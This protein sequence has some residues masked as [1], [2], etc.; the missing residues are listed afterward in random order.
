MTEFDVNVRTGTLR[1]RRFGTAEG[2]PML[3]VPGLTGNSRIF[4]FVGEQIGTGGR[5]LLA[6]DLPGRGFSPPTEPGAYGWRNEAR[7]V[8]DLA[9]ALK[10]DRFDLVGYSAGA[11]VAMQAAVLVPSRIRRLILIDGLGRP[12]PAAFWAVMRTMQ[13]LGHVYPS[14][15]AYLAEVR[16]LGTVDPWS[17]YWDR[18]FR[19]ELRPALG[20]VRSRASL[21]A[22]W[23]DTLYG[24]SHD[25]RRFWS[26]IST[27]TLVLEATRPLARPD[28]LFVTRRDIDRA[29]QTLP[30]FK[31]AAVDAN[32]YGVVTH[33]ETV[34][35]ICEFIA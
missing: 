30:H 7:D 34:D 6:F 25:P 1:T 2:E 23:E 21:L 24:M 26:R 32:H 14:V 15:E 27:P 22:V 10:I 18:Y 28:G 11:F 5:Q 13:R 33:R 19:Y 3:C 17:D 29:A 16:G 31:A 4:D 20:G 8:F 9:T 12:Q 35:K